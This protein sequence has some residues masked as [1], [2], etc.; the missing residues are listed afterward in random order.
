MSNN[1]LEIE[2]KLK[3]RD[4]P[5]LREQI[6]ALGFRVLEPRSLEFNIVFDTPSKKLKKRKHLLRIRRKDNQN[7]LTVKRP[8]SYKS[9]VAK[10]Y[11]I[12]EELEVTFSD[13]ETLKTMISALGFE[14]VFIYEK[15]RETLSRENI[16]LMIDETPIG[17]Y[18]EIEG[19]VHEIDDIA[20]QLGYGTE[21]YIT[22]NYRKLFKK[23]GGT[24]EMRF[25]T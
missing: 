17:T 25:D 6:S 20:A 9:A 12:R 24:G 13:F 11:K 21:D 1:N 16:H 22:A 4:L 7:I 15:Y 10:Q 8:T 18:L 2:I 19:E 5:K 23:S 3:V 14:P